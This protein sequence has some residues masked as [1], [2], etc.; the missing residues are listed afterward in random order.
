M[1]CLHSDLVDTVYS[2]CG[3]I[4]QQLMHQRL[5]I[6]IKGQAEGR[7]NC[8]LACDETID[9]YCSDFGILK[10]LLSRAQRYTQEVCLFTSFD[11][12]LVMLSNRRLL[13][14]CS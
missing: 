9:V 11:V 2:I 14:L 13:S 6:L 12:V 3:I 1:V 8:W 7:L 10:R 4:A 5:M